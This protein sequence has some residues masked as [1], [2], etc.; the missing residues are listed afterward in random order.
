MAPSEP[1]FF[2]IETE[3]PPLHC[4]SD[5]FETS[6][7]VAVGNL[8]A[9]SSDEEFDGVVLVGLSGLYAVAL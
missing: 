1:G 4:L 3:Y 8:F 2:L 6:E 9:Q 7:D 5:V